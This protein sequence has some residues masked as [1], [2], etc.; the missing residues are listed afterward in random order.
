MSNQNPDQIWDQLIKVVS[1]LSVQEYGP[2]LVGTLTITDD[3]IRQ[4][5]VVILASID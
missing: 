4:A 2:P 5:C 1:K 3:E